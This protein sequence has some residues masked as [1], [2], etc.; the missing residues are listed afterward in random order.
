[1][2]TDLRGIPFSLGVCQVHHADSRQL[3]TVLQPNSIDAVFTSPPYPNEKDYTR[4][5]RLESVILDFVTTSKS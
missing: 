3:S 2:A 5:T 4:T 1:M